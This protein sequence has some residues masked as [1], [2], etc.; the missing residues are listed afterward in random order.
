MGEEEEPI[1]EEPIPEEEEEDLDAAFEPEYS[2]D[3]R[4]LVQAVNYLLVKTQAIG[5]RGDK[6]RTSII[7]NLI[8]GG[9]LITDY[10]L[11]THVEAVKAMII[12]LKNK[13]F[14][15]CALKTDLTTQVDQ[16]TDD[17]IEACNELNTKIVLKADKTY[18][19]SQIANLVNGDLIVDVTSKADKSYVDSQDTI[20]DN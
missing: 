4:N 16:L 15:L 14:E 9:H 5:Y 10:A 17:I 20:L 19:D 8:I 7:G 6:Y 3:C 2:K 13:V 18:V 11:K 12:V 1:N